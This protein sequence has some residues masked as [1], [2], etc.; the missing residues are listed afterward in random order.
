MVKRATWVLTQ[1]AWRQLDARFAVEDQMIRWFDHYL[2]GIHKGVESG[3]A[4]RYYVM[5]AVGETAPLLDPPGKVQKLRVEPLSPVVLQKTPQ[6]RD[7]HGFAKAG[8]RQVR[9]RIGDLH[10]LERFLG[11]GRDRVAFHFELAPP[12]SQ[13]RIL[14]L[15]Q[16]GV[17]QAL[18]L[19]ESQALGLESL[20]EPAV[21]FARH[22]GVQHQAENAERVEE[23]RIEEALVH[24]WTFLEVGGEEVL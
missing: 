9:H 4:V 23:L 24:Q 20:V 14:R 1:M 5:G 11:L 21:A 17:D 22:D 16:Q 15:P 2:K 13:V 10:R 8:R 3:P 7:L 18:E 12:R 6:G 19:Q